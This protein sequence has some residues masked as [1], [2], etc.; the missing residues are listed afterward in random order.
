VNELQL[1]FWATLALAF[2]AGACLLWGILGA[3]LGAGSVVRSRLRSTDVEEVVPRA[4]V[5]ALQVLRD[6]RMSS[7]AALNFLLKSSPLAEAIALDLMRARVPLRVG[8][9]LLLRCGCGAGVGLLLMVLG[10]NALAIIPGAILGYFAP[11]LYVGQRLRRRISLIDSQLVEAL[12][13]SA[14]S[15][16]AGW[17]FM[18][19]MSQVARDMPAPISEEFSQVIQ[20]VSIGSSNEAAIQ[21]LIKRVPSYDLELVM[22]AVLIQRQIGGNLAEMMDNIA[23]TIRERTRLIADIASITAESTMSMW[24]LSL[25][26]V[27]LMVLLAVTQ[28]DYMVP[29][30]TD[31]RGRMMLVA[32]GVMEVLGVLIM[33]RLANVKV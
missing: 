22:T 26:P 15:L 19:A 7:I 12:S 2:A 21:N 6:R 8:E 20:E 30:M 23:F 18:Q 4:G 25:L 13:L 10:G 31:P 14:N 16:R 33:R 3:V 11:R 24:V 32:A 9:Y 28:A 5:T 27:F 1:A 29:F 17:G